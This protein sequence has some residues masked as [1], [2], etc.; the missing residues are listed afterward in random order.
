[1]SDSS[2]FYQPTILVVRWLLVLVSSHPGGHAA[3]GPTSKPSWWSYC[4]WFYRQPFWWSGVLFLLSKHP[5]CQVAP[6]YI[7]QRFWWS[8]GAWFYYIYPTILVLLSNH[9]GGQVALGYYLTIQVS[10]G[11]WFYHPTTLAVRWLLVL[12]SNHSDGQVVPG[13]TILAIVVVRQLMV[14][15]SNH[16][17]GQVAPACTIQPSWWSGGVWFYQ[18]TNMV[19]RWL[20]VPSNHPCDQE[21]PASSIQ[22]SW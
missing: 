8:G 16:P 2:W 3:L 1:V 10:V 21:A 19:A 22:P 4:Y 12:P 5:V 18:P 17:C 14:L 15:P 13:S 9:P 11:S 20:L 7:I 6:C